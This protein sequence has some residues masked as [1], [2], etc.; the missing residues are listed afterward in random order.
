MRITR[1]SNSFS[2]GTTAIHG[3]GATRRAGDAIAQAA[4]DDA[5]F[6]EQLHAA[7]AEL[8]RDGIT[9]AAVTQ[10]VVGGAAVGG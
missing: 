1:T 6:A 4:D 2:G 3:P 5:L 10:T 7:L 9:H 8:A